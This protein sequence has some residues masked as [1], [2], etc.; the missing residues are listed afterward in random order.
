MTVYNLGSINIDDVLRVPHLPAPG[1]TIAATDHH[2]GL[3]GKGANHSVAAARAGARVVHL[4]AVG[5]D[6]GPWLSALEGSGVD[7]SHVVRLNG[8]TGRADIWVDAAGENSI[9][10]LGGANH[11]VPEDAVAAALQEAAADDFLMLQNETNGQVAAARTAR[12]RGIRVIYSA[13]PFDADVA[14]QVMPFVSVLIVNAVEAAQLAAALGRE[15][16]PEDVPV[17]VVT[18]GSEGAVWHDLRAGSEIAVVPP[19]VTPVD[20][21]GAGDT[22]SGYLA[23]G[24][25]AGMDPEGAMRRAVSAA[26]LSVTRPGAA[27]AVPTWEEVDAALP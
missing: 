7:I 25:D 11:A 24:L 1:E 20:T 2:A 13:A 18:K 26:A 4:G 10:L 27:D 12:D 19:E 16:G 21:T 3:G 6:G 14:A 22:F 23:A 15:V 9:V 5:E 8:P 17:L